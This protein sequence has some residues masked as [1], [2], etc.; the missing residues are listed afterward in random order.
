MSNTVVV[1]ADDFNLRFTELVMAYYEG[2]VMFQDNAKTA[3]ENTQAA[4]RAALFHR[5]KENEVAVNAAPIF[6]DM[7]KDVPGFKKEEDTNEYFLNKCGDTDPYVDKT[8]KDAFGLPESY[9]SDESEADDG[10]GS[11]ESSDDEN[12]YEEIKF[13]LKRKR[14]VVKH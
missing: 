12:G 6:K 4:A 2:R 10:D 9:S 7:M 14:N 8:R 3:E 13:S 11:S 5:Y 1:L